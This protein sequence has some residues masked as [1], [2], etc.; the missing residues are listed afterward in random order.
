MHFVSHES[1]VVE[2]DPR[3]QKH[4]VDALLVRPDNSKR[5]ID[6]LRDTGALQ[7]HVS[8]SIVQDHEITF[9]GEKRLIQI[10]SNLLKTKG[11]FGHLHCSKT[12]NVKMCKNY[13]KLHNT[14]KTKHELYEMHLAEIG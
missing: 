12:Q 14:K 9:T 13:I 2:V 6:V 3:Y 11:P 7:S 5:P 8:S 4:S 1:E 10:K